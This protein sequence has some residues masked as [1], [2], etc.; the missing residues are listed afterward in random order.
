MSK[1]IG[2]FIKQSIIG[3]SYKAYIPA[4]LPP[5]PPIELQELF[6]YFEKA[7]E[8]LSELNAVIT[9]IPNQALF[10]YM[11]V[12]KEALLSS[13]IEGTQSSF[14]DLLL[15]EHEEKYVYKNY[16][17]ILETGTSPL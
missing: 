2:K 12:R 15:F 4:K 5:D 13:Q 17:K 16:L 3:E 1:G 9:A 10:L 11:Y 6:P 7:T 8:A 14:S